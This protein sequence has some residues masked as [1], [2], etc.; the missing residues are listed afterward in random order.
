MDIN[1][2]PVIAKIITYMIIIA[3]NI[4]K[5]EIDT[6]LKDVI[7]IFPKENA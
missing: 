3:L 5:K 7:F 4:L 1:V 2:L 6:I